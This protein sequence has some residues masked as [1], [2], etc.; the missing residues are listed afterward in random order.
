MT[1]DRR[2]T[3]DRESFE[4]GDVVRVSSGPFASFRAIV[5]EVDDERSR[6]GVAVSI[7][8]RMVPVELEF[9]EVGTLQADDG[10]QTTGDT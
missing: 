7:F 2:R 9:A 8:G 4:M 10:G 3:P 5:N 1:E 6:L